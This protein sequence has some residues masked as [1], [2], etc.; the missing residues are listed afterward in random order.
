[1]GEGA[2]GGGGKDTQSAKGFT[3]VYNAKYGMPACFRIHFQS[4]YR[5]LPV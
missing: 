4:L 3:K 1:M 5:C 2:G